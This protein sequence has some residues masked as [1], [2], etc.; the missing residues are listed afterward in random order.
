MEWLNITSRIASIQSGMGN[1]VTAG[2]AFKIKRL[3]REYGAHSHG[4]L[5]RLSVAGTVP[6]T[7]V[8]RS[9]VQCQTYKLAIVNGLFRRRHDFDLVKAA[10]KELILT[11]VE[12][13]P[14]QF[15]IPRSH[16]AMYVN[17]HCTC[18]SCRILI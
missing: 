12:V 8:F 2:L 16:R 13:V 11:G 1:S 4:T 7:D 5:G 3:T 15:V 9:F 18:I 10:L 17:L 14:V 6:A